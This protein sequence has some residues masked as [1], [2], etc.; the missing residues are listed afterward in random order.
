MPI[1]GAHAWLTFGR[2]AVENGLH[3]LY[4]EV[5]VAGRLTSACN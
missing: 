3:D 2:I 4:E 5:L 1:H